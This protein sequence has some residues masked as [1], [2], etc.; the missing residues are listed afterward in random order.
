MSRNLPTW[1]AAMEKIERLEAEIEQSERVIQAK[2]DCI[3]YLATR[4]SRLEMALIEERAKIL[5]AQNCEK[6][7]LKCINAARTQLQEE[8]AL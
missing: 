8:G 2:M 6:E 7:W 3:D 1:R 4:I 5:Q